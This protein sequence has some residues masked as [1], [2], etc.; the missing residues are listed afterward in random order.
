MS[1]DDDGMTLSLSLLRVGRPAPA[2]RPQLV[3]L[4][5]HYLVADGR[6]WARQGWV[7]FPGETA[8]RLVALTGSVVAA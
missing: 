5:N 1:A 3:E 6:T 2:P 4:T 8:P 7:R